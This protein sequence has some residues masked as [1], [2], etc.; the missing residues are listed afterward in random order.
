MNPK[1]ISHEDL[2]LFAMQLLTPEE[3]TE[4]LTH[5]EHNEAAREEFAQ[6]QGD[7]ATYALSAD[8]HSPPALARDRLLKKVAKEKKL[9]A[10]NRPAAAP[11]QAQEP[12][13]VPRG[14]RVLHVAEEPARRS[15][16]AAALAWAGW[17]VAA[18]LGAVAGLQFHQ[19]DML[20]NQYNTQSARL[21]TATTESFRAQQV[22]Q[23]LSDVGAMQVSLHLNAG[24]APV[25]PQ[26]E[27]HAAYVAETGSL[28]FVG[29]HLSPLREYKTY[30]LWVIPQDGRDAIPAGTFKPDERG[31]ATVILP[32][33]PRGVAAKMF[34]VTVEDDGGA[35]QGP[36]LPIVLA[37]MYFRPQR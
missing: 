29:T 37:G 18:G 10:I 30:E 2:A 16:T 17:A 4:I 5:L 28:V 3:N 26:P 23:T 15:S 19:R 8:L 20:Q 21:A 6:I 27:G 11:A 13:L 36:T 32:E 25:P 33:L 1:T 7:L 22:L 35:K 14:G 24:G 31:Y 34:G 9:I 12:M